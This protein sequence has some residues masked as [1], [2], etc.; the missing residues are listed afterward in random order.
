MEVGGK[1]AVNGQLFRA[2]RNKGKVD[3]VLTVD[4]RLFHA[5]AWNSLTSTITTAL[6][7]PLLLR[8]LKS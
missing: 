8:A 4:V 3:A 1:D 6:P 2:R 7:L 5:L